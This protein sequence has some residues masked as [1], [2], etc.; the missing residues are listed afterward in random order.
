MKTTIITIFL[1]SA[2]WSYSQQKPFTYLPPGTIITINGVSTTLTEGAYLTSD[3][4]VTA[5]LHDMNTLDYQDSLIIEQNRQ[6]A[7]NKHIIS[8]QD[9]IIQVQNKRIAWRD[10]SLVFKDSLIKTLLL[11]VKVKESSSVLQFEGF[12]SHL[13]GTYGLTRDNILKPFWSAVEWGIST[14]VGFRVLN[15]VRLAVEPIYFIGSQFKIQA[16]LGYKIF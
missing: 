1:I 9:S 10:S 3:K 14:E 8:A 2:I 4:V 7:D 6:I 5:Y 16:K 11:P 13:V 15:T 12:W